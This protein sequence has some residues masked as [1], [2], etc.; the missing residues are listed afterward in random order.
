MMN[1]RKGCREMCGGKCTYKGK[2]LFN[3]ELCE[4]FEGFGG[5]TVPDKIV[6]PPKET[7][8]LR[9]NSFSKLKKYDKVGC[10]FPMVIS[11]EFRMRQYRDDDHREDTPHLDF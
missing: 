7:N 4:E 6:K 8:S 1:V 9:K 3:G 10:D 5:P 2:D 11:S